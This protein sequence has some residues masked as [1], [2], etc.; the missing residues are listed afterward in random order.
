MA[1]KDDEARKKVLRAYADRKDGHAQLCADIERNEKAFLAVVERG[2]DVEQWETQY[3]PP[4]AQ[5]VVDT[6]V[7]NLIDD[8]VRVNVRP[9]PLMSDFETRERHIAGARA[10]ELLLSYQLDRDRWSEKKATFMQQAAICGFTV[11]K[12]H[13]VTEETSVRTLDPVEVPTYDDYGNQIGTEIQQEENK[14]SHV[15]RDD[16]TIDVVRVEDFMFDGASLNIQRS[17]WIIHRVYTTLDDLKRLQKAG[18][19]SGVNQIPSDPDGYHT[20]PEDD[21][22]SVIDELRSDKRNKNRV[23]LMEYWCKEADGSQRAITLADR[24]YVIADRRFT[25]SHGE[26]PF[27]VCTTRPNRFQI[28]GRAILDSIRD[29]QSY[30]WTLMNQRLSNLRL[31]ANTVVAY[32]DDLLDRDLFE[33][34]PGATVAVQGDVRE[35]IMPLQLDATPAMITLQAEALMKGDLQNLTGG[36]PFMSGTESSSIDQKT[37]TGVSIVTSLAQRMVASQKQYITWAEEKMFQQ[38]LHLNQQNIDSDRLIPIIGQEGAE[39]F[40]EIGPEVLAGTYHVNL[41]PSSESLMRQERRAE[42]MA[43]LQVANTVAPTFQLVGAPLNLK[44]FMEDYL[45]AMDVDDPEKYFAAQPQ[46]PLGGQ[47]P[48]QQPPGPPAPPGMAAPGGVT[49]P[50]A[51]DVNAPSNQ[52]SQS[53]MAALQ[54]MMAMSGGAANGGPGY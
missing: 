25:F 4:Y 21:F 49:A 43:M 20:G 22:T 6:V 41:T 54:R 1:K 14:G 35:A 52:Q 45:E 15:I 33:I 26:Y 51:T 46:Q 48:P 42:K 40:M 37:A 44:A 13:W 17:P 38:M 30:L 8:R 2:A 12:V 39:A 36:M 31:V 23:E 9:R 27:V 47:G 19:Y 29:A 3:T 53:G 28:P 16:P 34:Y 11:A 24:Q 7:A 5:Q 32:R 18:V 50:Q 10:H